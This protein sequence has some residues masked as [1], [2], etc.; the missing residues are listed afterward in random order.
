VNDF[1]NFPWKVF[2]F[3]VDCSL[4]HAVANLTNYKLKWPELGNISL[5]E[6]IEINLLTNKDMTFDP[7]GGIELPEYFND[8]YMPAPS[9]SEFKNWPIVSTFILDK[10]HVT[11]NPGVMQPKENHADEK[12]EI[13]FVS[14][15]MVIRNFTIRNKGFPY[16]EC[17]TIENKV[18]MTQIDNADGSFSTNIKGDFRINI[19]K[20][21]RFI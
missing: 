3:N 7:S 11:P 14:P 9:P 12:W 8:P 21:I 19:I 6:W 1:E 15:R 16:A 2:E 20:P 13:F 10:T 5:L 18:I 4:K 17:F